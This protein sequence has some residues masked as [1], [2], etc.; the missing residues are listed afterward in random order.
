VRKV[1]SRP[2]LVRPRVCLCGSTLVCVCMNRCRHHLPADELALSESLTN[3]NRSF[4][5][6]LQAKGYEVM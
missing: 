1:P 5:D 4:R 3:A 6:V 2:G